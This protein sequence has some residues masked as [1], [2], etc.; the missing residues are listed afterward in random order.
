M[1]LLQIYYTASLNV[2]EGSCLHSMASYFLKL[3]LTAGPKP[4]VLSL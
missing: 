1:G 4:S 3:A 2:Y